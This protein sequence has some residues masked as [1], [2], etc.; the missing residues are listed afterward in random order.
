MVAGLAA[1]FLF[2]TVVI[3]NI[4][5]FSSSEQV[6]SPRA[7]YIET[8]NDVE[9]EEQLVQKAILNRYIQADV[10]AVSYC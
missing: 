3:F 4:G 1:S 10:N 2:F 5:L 8:T 7:S 9:L 6:V